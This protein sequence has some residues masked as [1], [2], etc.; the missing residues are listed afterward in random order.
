MLYTA[1][2]GIFAIQSAKGDAKVKRDYQREMEKIIST[3]E[4]RKPSLLL[5]ACCAPCSTS[6]LERLY[7][8]FDITLFYYN[9]NI[10]PEEEYVLRAEQFGKIPT[11]ADGTV[12]LIVAKYDKNEFLSRIN[13]FE[14]EPEGGGRCGICFD[15]RLGKTAE[16]AER[17]GFEY[18]GTTLT[19]SPHKNAPIINDIGEELAKGR[20]SVW[21]PSDFKKK[22]GY[23]RSTELCRAY[24]IYRQNYCGCGLGAR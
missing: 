2:C 19:V 3:F 8:N 6:V 1:K 20:K 14:D 4:G 12:G 11:V 17:E 15:V 18:F 13:G 23:L 24:G 10:M 22:N 21:L 5:H 9:P 16:V 7:D